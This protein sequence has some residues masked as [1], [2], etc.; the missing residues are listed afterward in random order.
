MVSSVSSVKTSEL[1]MCYG[2]MAGS[3]VSTSATRSI[4]SRFR[5]RR[6]CQ[7][8]VDAEGAVF[9][10]PEMS[11]SCCT[12]DLTSNC[13]RDL[14]AEP[15]RPRIRETERERGPVGQKQSRISRRKSSAQPLREAHGSQVL[16]TNVQPRYGKQG[17]GGR[18]KIGIKRKLWRGQQRYGAF[19]CSFFATRTESSQR[20]AYCVRALRMFLP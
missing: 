9:P 6:Q 1:L 8:C 5:G 2:R 15:W 14:G 7:T 18:C 13:K 12:V 19:N 10:R 11:L 17:C 20:K 3:T 4:P 16:N